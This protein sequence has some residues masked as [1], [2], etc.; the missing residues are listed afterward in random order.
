M[1]KALIPT[2][3]NSEEKNVNS[4]MDTVSFTQF[5]FPLLKYHQLNFLKLLVQRIPSTEICF[6]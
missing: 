3:L 5:T 6:K 2:S 1:T 4:A